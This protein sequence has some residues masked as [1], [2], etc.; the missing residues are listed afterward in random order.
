MSL[1][2]PT[3]STKDQFLLLRVVLI[4]PITLVCRRHIREPKRL[5]VRKGGNAA[6]LLKAHQG[7]AKGKG[8]QRDHHAERASVRAGAHTMH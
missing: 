1:Q 6:P 2:R 8:Y 3:N 5:E 7:G 4:R